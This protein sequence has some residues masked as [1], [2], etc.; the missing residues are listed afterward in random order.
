MDGSG[1]STELNNYHATG[2]MLSVHLKSAYY[3][4]DFENSKR[5]MTFFWKIK[6]KKASKINFE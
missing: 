3:S 2:K 1:F 5:E 6:Y 4:T